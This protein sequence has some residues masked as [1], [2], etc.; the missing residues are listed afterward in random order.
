VHVVLKLTDGNSHGVSGSRPTCGL[1]FGVQWPYQAFAAFQVVTYTSS[2]H[3]LHQLL[4]KKLLSMV[5]PYSP[6]GV[7]QD[8][9]LT[10]PCSGDTCHLALERV[11]GSLLGTVVA[12]TSLW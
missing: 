7:L 11:I 3:K 10:I 9:F 12:Q 2:V 1:S 4:L 6:D 8:L 5:T